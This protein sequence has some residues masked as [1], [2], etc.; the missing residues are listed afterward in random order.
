MK[1]DLKLFLTAS[2]FCRYA[3]NTIKTGSLFDPPSLPPLPGDEFSLKGDTG[4]PLVI[5]AQI[6][7]KEALDGMMAVDFFVNIKMPNPHPETWLRFV[8]ERGKRSCHLCLQYD[9]L[10]FAAN[11]P[12]RPKLPLHYRCRCRY[13]P[14]ATDKA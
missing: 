6:E 2:Y 5:G 12:D 14:V 8:A 13:E 4:A 7:C 1:K 10:V 9:G 11:D 3:S